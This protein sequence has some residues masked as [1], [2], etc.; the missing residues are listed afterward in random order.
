MGHGMT[1]MMMMMMAAGP[2]EKPEVIRE[3]ENLQAR[4]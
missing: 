4:R 3:K 2:R 1:M